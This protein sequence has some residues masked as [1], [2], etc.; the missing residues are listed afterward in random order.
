MF[1]IVH[2]AD[3]QIQP[4]DFAWNRA[5]AIPRSKAMRYRHYLSLKFTVMDMI[6]TFYLKALARL[7]A[8]ELRSC[9]QESLLKAGHCYGP[10]D[11]VS[12]IIVN[13]IWYNTVSPPSQQKLELDMVSTKSL[14]RIEARSFYG[15]VSFL[16]ARGKKLYGAIRTLLR[17]NWTLGVSNSLAAFGD[18]TDIYNA[19]RVAG[20][21]AWQLAPQPCR[22]SRVS[23]LMQCFNP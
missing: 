6:H 11:P 23:I 5:L 7:P 1:I 22:I 8:S 10:F 14:L 12:N 2:Y 18:Q 17:S 19:L 4:L 15:L 20:E 16:C 3:M 13:T 21:A 9:Y